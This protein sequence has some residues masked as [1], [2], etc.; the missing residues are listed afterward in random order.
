MERHL[1]TLW[2][3]H[4][5]F[6]L[7][8]VVTLGVL[9]VWLPVDFVLREHDIVTPFGFND[10][11]AYAQAA[12]RWQAGEVI[13]VE[14]DA[15]G[16][17]GS[18]LYPPVAL[19]AYLPFTTFDFYTGA[20]LFGAVS[21][22]L[23]WVGLEATVRVLGYDPSIGERL[24]ALPALFAFQPVLR[25]FKWAQ[26]ATLLTA[27]LCFAFYAHE[28]GER[29]PVNRTYRVLSGILTTLGS[30]FKLFFATAGAHLLRDRVR[31]AGALGTAAVVG[32][33]S[34]A[35]FG[36]ENH[37]TYLEVL[38]WG[39]GWG[40][41]SHPS[42]WDTSAA[43]RPLHVF[44]GWGMPMRVVGVLAIIAL[45]IVGRRRHSDV[46]RWSTFALGVAAVP[47]LAPTADTHDL[48][49]L[50][51]PAIILVAVEF[52]HPSGRPWLPVVAILLVHLHRYVVELLVNTPAWIPA[53]TFFTERAGW[54]QPAMWATF[55]LVGLA[56]LRLLD[57][58]ME[59]D[60]ASPTSDGLEPFDG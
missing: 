16:F 10:F 22:V 13:Y 20:I 9:L 19:L 32:V 6:L 39:K 60:A 33:T 31:L 36:I 27:A 41:S 12:D 37:V 30:A 24:V 29:G 40:E 17:H 18:F 58:I 11:S 44:G 49:V 4:L 53:G 55:I 54:F 7:A 23:L 48:A 50:L 21:F 57:E 25:D 47:L 28:R 14:D 8:V 42:I 15:G 43:Y 59:Y 51:L 3:S 1:R 45:A 35:L 52:D 2:R 38:T 46:A 26:T 5:L 34:L 56:A